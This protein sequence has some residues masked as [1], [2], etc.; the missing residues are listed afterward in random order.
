MVRGLL[1]TLE[2]LRHRHADPTTQV[3]PDEREASLKKSNAAESWANESNGCTACCVSGTQIPDVVQSPDPL[4]SRWHSA[5]PRRTP[6][7]LISGGQPLGVPAIE[8]R[9]NLSST[10]AKRREGCCRR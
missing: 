10:Q 9:R 5:A 2:H 4:A 6:L 3:S 1:T 7:A 8:G